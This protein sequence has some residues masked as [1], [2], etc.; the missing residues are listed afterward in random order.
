[1]LWSLQQALQAWTAPMAP[2]VLTAASAQNRRGQFDWEIEDPDVLK[3]T[4]QLPLSAFAKHFRSL[5]IDGGV[6]RRELISTYW[7]WIE[8]NELRPILGWGRWDREIKAAGFFR[9]RTSLPG[10]PWHYDVKAS[11]RAVVVKFARRQTTR[12]ERKAAA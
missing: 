10:R 1:M 11:G 6:S 12:S 7:E 4:N 5:G 9:R 2:T 3:R 8:A